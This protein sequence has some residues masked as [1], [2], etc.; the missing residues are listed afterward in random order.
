LLLSSDFSASSSGDV[1]FQLTWPKV[2]C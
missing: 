1:G 2:P